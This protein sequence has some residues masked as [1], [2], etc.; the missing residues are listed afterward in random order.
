MP[1]LESIQFDLQS[2]DFGIPKRTVPGTSHQALPSHLVR[3]GDFAP[4]ILLPLAARPKERAGHRVFVTTASVADARTRTRTRTRTRSAIATAM[5]FLDQLRAIDAFP[6]HL[7]EYRLKTTH[8][9]VVSIV[10]LM[11]MFYLLVSEL[12]YYSAIEVG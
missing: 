11:L 5:A 8:G 4:A 2:F 7:D 3:L 10:S 1:N 9:A 12:S 6:K